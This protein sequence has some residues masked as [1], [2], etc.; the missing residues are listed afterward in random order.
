MSDVCAASSTDWRQQYDSVWHVDFEYREDTNYHPVPVS[1]FAYEQHSGTEIFLRREQLLNLRR[2]PFG[3]GQS[4]S[5]GG[6]CG[7]CRAFV[8]RGARVAVSLQC[9]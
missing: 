6:L 5:A 3:V 2:A 8:F 9:A 1:M 7:E 4:R